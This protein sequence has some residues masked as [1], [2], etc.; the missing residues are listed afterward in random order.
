MGLGLELAEAQQSWL[1]PCDAFD[2]LCRWNRFWGHKHDRKQEPVL[3][4]PY[5]CWPSMFACERL[6][7][8]Q[9]TEEPSKEVK[10]VGCHWANEALSHERPYR[11]GLN[12]RGSRSGI[13]L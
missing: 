6:V 8:L 1:H 4:G 2:Q 3:L 7:N 11:V 10:P 5:I 13:R 12:L 9:N